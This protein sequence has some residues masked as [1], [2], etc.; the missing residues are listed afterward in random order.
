MFFQSFATGV[1]VYTT[2]VLLETAAFAL[3]YKQSLYLTLSP[4]SAL[5]EDYI[6]NNI[7]LCAIFVAVHSGFS[8]RGP[9]AQ[10]LEPVDTRLRRSL[11]SLISALTLQFCICRWTAGD[12]FY[13]TPLPELVITILRSLALFFSMTSL[14]AFDPE[15]M[16][17]LTDACRDT[18]AD[19][20]L[21]SPSGKL[22]RLYS[23]CRHP[24]I[25]GPLTLLLL[26]PTVTVDRLALALAYLIYNAAA[27]RTDWDDVKYVAD[28]T[29]FRLSWLPS[30]WYGWIGWYRDE[31]QRQ[32]APS[33][34]HY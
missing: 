18:E 31:E 32:G 17:G 11:Y 21:Y 22:K 33:P 24:L 13:S 14:L 7:V 12:V 25:L 8:S 20:E 1:Y 34:S 4:S 2:L 29:Y 10:L 26:S 16:V 19:V 23:H 27:F 3:S 15:E 5:F 28:R 6:V 30:T 9:F